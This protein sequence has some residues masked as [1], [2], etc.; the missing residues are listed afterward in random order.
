LEKSNIYL[1]TLS[2]LLF[3]TIV[4]LISVNETHLSVYIGFLAME[5]FACALI[6]RPGGDMYKLISATLF[7]F[8]AVTAALTVAGLGF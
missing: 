6:Y 7:I 4:S 1:I 2:F 8:W 3:A 5:Y